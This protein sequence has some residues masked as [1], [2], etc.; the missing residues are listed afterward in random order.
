MPKKSAAI[1]R[2]VLV[3]A[4]AVAV[5]AAPRFAASADLPAGKAA[6]GVAD[7][8]ETTGAIGAPAAATAASARHALAAR[9]RFVEARAAMERALLLRDTVSRP[10]IEA[11]EAC[12]RK[13]FSELAAIEGG[14][15]PGSVDAAKAA[16]K[17]TRE[18]Y[19]AGLK[20]INPP[21]EGLLELPLPMSVTEKAEAAATALDR[22][23]ETGT[24]EAEAPPSVEPSPQGAQAR[25]HPVSGGRK[26]DRRRH[27]IMRVTR[28]TQPTPVDSY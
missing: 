18:W 12:L 14:G 23:V 5:C 22:L 28:V 9:A 21:A 19:Q 6:R 17:S 26:S 27:S 10:A 11:L 25:P 20:I 8:T 7:A 3:L 24:K 15:L 2:F 4:A 13:L 16:V 1:S